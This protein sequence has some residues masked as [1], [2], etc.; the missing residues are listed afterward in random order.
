MSYERPTT[1]EFKRT[2]IPATRYAI[3]YLKR[4][5]ALDLSPI[6]CEIFILLEENGGSMTQ[7]DLEDQLDLS[8][9]TLSGVLRTMEKNGFVEKVASDTDRRIMVVTLTD[10]GGE[11]YSEA[12]KR[13]EELDRK[14]FDGLDEEEMAALSKALVKIRNNI[15]SDYSDNNIRGPRLPPLA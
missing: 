5:M 13:F 12:M 9:S 8:K 2:E 3:N 15:S 4:E 7:R 1:I 14:I 11:I 6:Q 10:E